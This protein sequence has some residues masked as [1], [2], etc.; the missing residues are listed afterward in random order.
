MDYPFAQ[1]VWIILC[2]G[3]V[4][5][6][7]SITLEAYFGNQIPTKP[8]QMVGVSDDSAETTYIQVD[9]TL[10]QS[11]ANP[12]ESLDIVSTQTATYIVSASGFQEIG[13]AFTLSCNSRSSIID[14]KIVMRNS[15]SEVE[16][17]EAVE[18]TAV[19]LAVEPT[20]SIS[21]PASTSR[22]TLTTPAPTYIS[23]TRSAPQMASSG[24]AGHPMVARASI[25]GVVI[26]S[27]V[28]LF[29]ILL[30][31][32]LVRRRRRRQSPRSAQEAISPCGPPV[33]YDMPDTPSPLATVRRLSR[34]IQVFRSKRS[35]TRE[36]ER[37]RMDAQE[38]L[39][40]TQEALNRASSSHEEES[41]LRQQISELMEIVRKIEERGV[42]N[43]L[44]PAY[45]SQP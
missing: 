45:G 20:A 21:I 14:C 39:R 29:L 25:I 9:S 28:I 19:V 24:S 1:L 8:L 4:Y 33:P 42:A 43:D 38:A 36:R 32:W 27:A 22:A 18:A 35:E 37:A 26:S 15:T 44:P 23:S 41:S 12:S 16:G 2:T 40:A 5:C 34:P 30:T 17:L 7:S 31:L 13:E 11:A 6:Q 10:I 3:Y